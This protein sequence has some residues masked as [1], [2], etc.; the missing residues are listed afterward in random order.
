MEEF[1]EG[2]AGNIDQ[3]LAHEAGVNHTIN[4]AT[5]HLKSQNN[6]T[7]NYLLHQMLWDQQDRVD[8]DFLGLNGQD[9]T[10]LEDPED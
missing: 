7:V 10:M 8:P 4:S 9:T 2:P 5:P 3:P 6:R 1:K